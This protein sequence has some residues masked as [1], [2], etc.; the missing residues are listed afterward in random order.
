[1]LQRYL[2]LTAKLTDLQIPNKQLPSA[3]SQVQSHPKLLDSKYPCADTLHQQEQQSA[4]PMACKHPCRIAPVQQ[5]AEPMFSEH[6]YGIK[7]QQY[8]EPIVSEHPCGI[9]L[10]QQKQ[11]SFESMASDHPCGVTAEKKEQQSACRG[12]H[13]PCSSVMLE[14]CQGAGRSYRQCKQEGNGYSRQWQ[15]LRR[16]HLFSNWMHKP[17]HLQDFIVG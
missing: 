1:M 4:W 11:Q 8:P 14:G 7:E 6:P 12:A 2:N 17:E 16:Q 10:A 3:D 5:S 15:E 9:A 13:Q